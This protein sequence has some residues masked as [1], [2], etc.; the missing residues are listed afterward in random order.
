MN[1]ILNGVVCDGDN[2]LKIVVLTVKG[3]YRVSCFDGLKPSMY[4]MDGHLSAPLSPSEITCLLGAFGTGLL[5][6]AVIIRLNEIK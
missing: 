5:I 3:H 2:P 1:L 4:Y 6:K